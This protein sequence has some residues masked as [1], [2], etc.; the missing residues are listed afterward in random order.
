MN[1]LNS[2]DNSIPQNTKKVNTF[3]CNVDKISYK[4]K[5][6]AKKDTAD[7]VNRTKSE[8]RMMKMNA[9]RLSKAVTQGYSF[10][11]AQL[12]GTK[13]ENFVSQKLAIVDIDNEADI[14]MASNLNADFKKLSKAEKTL[15]AAYAILETEGI[16]KTPL[17]TVEAAI[18]TLEEHQIFYA[19]FY[20]SFSHSTCCPKFR[21][22]C[23]LDK[24]IT[25]PEQA[26]RLN[27]YLISLFPQADQSCH[28]LDRFYYGTDKGLATEV[29]NR[30]T[31]IILPENSE[32]E[33]IKTEPESK[34]SERKGDNKNSFEPKNSTENKFN[35]THEIQTYDLLSYVEHTTNTKGKKGSNDNY[36]INPCPVCGH[37]NDFYIDVKKNVYKCH[38]ASNGSGGNII[39]YLEQTRKLDRKA[40]REYFIYDIMKQ[41]RKEKYK[42]TNSQT[43]NSDTIENKSDSSIDTDN[44]SDIN[45]WEKITSR[46]L[47][48]K[49]L[50]NLDVAE[51]ECE[52]SNLR[53][54]A[55]TLRRAAEFDNIIKAVK[56][57]L[58]AKER[59]EYFQKNPN[60][61][62]FENCP[63]KLNC[64][65]YRGD[66][67]GIYSYKWLVIPQPLVITKIFNDIE[68]N[69]VKVELAAKIKGK[70]IF[71]TVNK[72]MIANRN[73]IVGLAN[74]GIMVNSQNAD[75][76]LA[77]LL[78]LQVENTEIIPTVSGVSHMGYINGKTDCFVPYANN[79]IYSGD[80]SY[81]TI[82]NSVH[83]KG[84]FS[85]WKELVQA[86]R[87]DSLAA[88][89]ALNAS[90]ASPLIGRLN[91]LVFF[92]HL[93]GNS[94]TGK[95][96]SLRL[97]ASV[98]GNPNEYMR[99]LNSTNVGLE[100]N[101]H[102][103]HNL[104]FILDE[105]QTI[106]ND[107]PSKMIYSMTQGQGRMRGTPTGVEK[108]INQWRCG[109]ITTGEQPLTNDYSG[110]GEINR[111]I[112]I[113][114]GGMVFKEPAKVYQ[115]TSENYGHA[116]KYYMECL[117]DYDLTQMI[118]KW[119]GYIQTQMKKTSGKQRM[120][121]GLLLC[122]NELAN[123]IFFGYDENQAEND[124]ADY[125]EKLSESLAD[126]KDIDITK[127]AYDFII[128]WVA[129]NSNKFTA[130]EAEQYECW[131]K[132][133]QHTNTVFISGN[134]LD[135][136][137]TKAKF[138]YRAILKGFDERNFI[139][140]DS[141]ETNSK[142]NTKIFKLNG[143]STR[144]I[145]LKLDI[146]DMQPMSA[147]EFQ[148][149]FS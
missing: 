32:Q 67:S 145:E 141:K 118:Y 22:V 47:L 23:V 57:D 61:L 2:Y 34:Q 137:L 109:F 110:A 73:K 40:A 74:N 140:N 55:K 78:A 106:K 113:Y 17:T 21:I 134:A 112:D 81:E 77:Y 98:W 105:L 86:V 144:G 46:E 6:E 94:D 43:Q 91:K 58:E 132:I 123:R 71:I 35:L 37:Q 138:N 127:R 4:S 76:I 59:E 83:S 149:I 45:S 119:D 18:K 97:A 30:T 25:N 63:I 70:W 13:E 104:P 102:F 1:Q 39:N 126:S 87:D 8:N 28:N 9:E 79:L 7:I 65:D 75:N 80:S 107:N 33:Q 125:W 42:K 121:A 31:N 124:T 85:E 128:S 103:F 62:Y 90:L 129:E 136:A 133:I 19:F 54:T 135:N 68:S 60:G 29:Y 139:V 41:P 142:R 72:E 116:G 93:W 5:A 56:A 44:S 38:S 99:N 130:S 100:R 10:T 89:T 69:E 108:K 148:K 51:R 120:N 96:V 111:I 143:I 131:G 82:Y 84:N 101:A 15:D 146:S 95:T 3:Y 20:Y 64:S 12:N 147:E 88:R 48:Y 24:E 14:I 117:E 36:L 27:K 49:I 11:T 66:E 52:I 114:V 50:S 92:T 16:E 26:K 53:T 122:A 115:I